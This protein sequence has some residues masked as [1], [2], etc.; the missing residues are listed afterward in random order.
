MFERITVKSR[1]KEKNNKFL[2]F[3]EGIHSPVGFGNTPNE[4]IV[5]CLKLVIEGAAEVINQISGLSYTDGL[6]E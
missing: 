2:A 3:F 1:P 6:D 4:A 5:C